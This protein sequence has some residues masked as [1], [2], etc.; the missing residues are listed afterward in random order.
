MEFTQTSITTLRKDIDY[1]SKQGRIRKIRG[2]IEFVEETTAYRYINREKKFIK[3]KEAIGIA[4]QELIKDGDILFLTNGTTTIQVARNIDENKHITII[5]NGLDIVLALQDKPN[6]NVILLGGIVEYASYMIIGPTV[7]KM[8]EGFSPAKIFMGAGGL[9][10]EKGI[11][12]YDLLTSTYYPQ[13][14]KMVEEVIVVA[15]HSKIGKNE[16]A[17]IG[18]IEDI[19][20]LVTDENISKESIKVFEKYNINCIISKIDQ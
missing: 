3:E 1:L 7:I 2:G 6:V 11:T 15:D 17:R 9:T 4:A 8:L 14:V 5:T 16:L 12:V 18:S 13:I 10:E 20:V 19:D